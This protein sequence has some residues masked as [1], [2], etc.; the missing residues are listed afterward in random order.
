MYLCWLFAVEEAANAIGATFDEF[1]CYR[2]VKGWPYL[3]PGRA[4][5]F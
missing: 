5:Q 1:E 3:P 4:C 2:L